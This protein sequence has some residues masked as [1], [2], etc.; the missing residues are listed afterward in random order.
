MIATILLVISTFFIMLGSI[1]GF[2]IFVIR[3]SKDKCDGNFTYLRNCIFI[4]LLGVA[5]LLVTLILIVLG[6]IPGKV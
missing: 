5:I 1:T 6:I 3:L 2:V 4:Y